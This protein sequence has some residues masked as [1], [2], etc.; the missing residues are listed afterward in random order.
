MIVNQPHT[1]LPK[2]KLPFATKWLWWILG[3]AILGLGL[4]YIPRSSTTSPVEDIVFCG[5]EEK[6]W[7]EGKMVFQGRGGIFRN[8]H[9][10]SDRASRTGEFSSRTTKKDIYGLSYETTQVKAGERYRASVW[11]MGKQIDQQLPG[12]EHHRHRRI[13]FLPTN[14]SAH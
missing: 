10:Q 2:W 8:A 5:A 9:T 3:L 6:V 7:Y 12:R 13:C 4:S 14:G 11:R 1:G